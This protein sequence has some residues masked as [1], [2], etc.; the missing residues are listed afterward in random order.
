[1]ACL[2]QRMMPPDTDQP[3]N[4]NAASCLSRRDAVVAVM[5]A[6]VVLCAGGLRM[7]TGVCGVYH[8]DAIYVSTAKALASGHG[9]R[10]IDVPGE[11][12][13]TKY[14]WLYPAILALI[15]HA[16][17]SFPANLAAMQWLTLSFAAAAVSLGYLYLVRF[18]YC[19]RAVAAS[20]GLVCATAP[21][22]LYFAVHTMAEMPFSLLTLC[23]LW[24]VESYLWRGQMTQRSQFGWGCVLALPFLCRS[25]GA[26]VVVSS[27]AVL[28]WNKRPVGWYLAGAMC[29]AAPWVVWSLGGLGI[30]DRNPVDGYY[31]DYFGCWS[32]TGVA[33]AGRVVSVNSQ[34]VAQGTGELALE[35]VSAV[36]A[37]WL[38]Y[39]LTAGVLMLIGLA[40]WL[41]TVGD[42]SKAR[43]LAWML[44]LYLAAM[45]IW[46]WLPHRFLVPILPLLVA[47][48]LLGWATVLQR[49]SKPPL[50]QAFAAAVMCAIVGGNAVLL[51]RH[52][53]HIRNT[54]YPLPTLGGERVE[55]PAFQRMFG[56]L[57]HN[58]DPDDVIAAGMDSMMALYTDRRAIHAFVYNPGRLF[59]SEQQLIFFPLDELAGIL[60]TYRPRYLVQT[61]MPGFAEE[62]PL[63]NSIQQLHRRYPEWL[64]LRY[65][66]SDPRFMVFELDWNKRPADRQNNGR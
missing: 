7:A 40:T 53:D 50:R 33:M 9:Y 36:L 62:M 25:I 45:L 31:T 46:S 43:P 16:W 58:S 34:V 57:R 24:G 6:L 37:G 39:E 18:R 49:L 66:D 42:L 13:Q 56:W 4:L 2:D 29:V 12:V 61:P 26:V 41:T 32:S 44:A 17:P 11:P 1:M 54:G 35:G 22:F 51:A 3:A 52:F 8:D 28:L 38:D 23:A 14:P 47:Y 21:F 55:W 27:L 64:V 60:Q 10:L 15:W 59:Y 5:L 20:A 63:M 19:S 30:W 65:E 48:L